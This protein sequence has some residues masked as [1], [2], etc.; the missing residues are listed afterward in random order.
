MSLL[1]LPAA[2]YEA[3]QIT[4][5]DAS[6]SDRIMPWQRA[7]NEGQESPRRKETTKMYKQKRNKDE[8]LTSKE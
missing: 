3:P 5:E 6:D 4:S 2:G 1:K 8:D 7:K